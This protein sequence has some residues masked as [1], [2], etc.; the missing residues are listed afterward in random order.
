MNVWL[1]S[2]GPPPPL[3]QILGS[4]YVL[5]LFDPVST[6]LNRAKEFRMNEANEVLRGYLRGGRRVLSWSKVGLT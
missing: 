4:F 6:V 2:N 5:A 1:G 3:L